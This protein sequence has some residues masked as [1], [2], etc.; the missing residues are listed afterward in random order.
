MG[1]I[2]QI[3][4]NDSPRVIC[5]HC[6]ETINMFLKP[7]GKDV[8]KI[9]QDK[10]PKCRGNIVIGLLIL[11]DINMQRFLSSLRAMVDAASKANMIG[12]KPK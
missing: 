4:E 5:P 3:M 10:C 12:G 6:K 9:M 1:E 2:I 7:W 11:C 8:T